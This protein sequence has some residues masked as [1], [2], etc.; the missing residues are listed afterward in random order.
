LKYWNQEQIVETCEKNKT[1][2]PIKNKLNNHCDFDLA[3]DGL[4]GIGAATVGIAVDV[5]ILKLT[6]TTKF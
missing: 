5:E 2:N 4:E 3:T 6:R 1:K